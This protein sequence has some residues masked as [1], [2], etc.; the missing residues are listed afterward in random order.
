MSIASGYEK[1]SRREQMAYDR[2]V[3]QREAKQRAVSAAN[4]L[5]E[6]CGSECTFSDIDRMSAMYDCDADEAWSIYL[7][8]TDRDC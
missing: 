7:A 5:L 8:I 2:E 4:A 3:A 1:A 6:D